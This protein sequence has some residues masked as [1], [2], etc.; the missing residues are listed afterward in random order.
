MM[1]TIL[2]KRRLLTTKIKMSEFSHSDGLSMTREDGNRYRAAMG[3]A[4]DALSA[5]V[6]EHE[7]L[8]VEGKT[9]VTA[10][11][12]ID[13]KLKE[14]PG[15]AALLESKK[16]A[17]SKVRD[18]AAAVEASAAK[19]TQRI[20]EVDPKT[21]PKV[22]LQQ[23]KIYHEKK[24]ND[25]L[26][27]LL[28]AAQSLDICFVIDATGSMNMG[29]VFNAVSNHIRSVLLELKKS[30]PRMVQR[31]SLVAYRDPG[32]GLKHFEVQEFTG[33]VSTFAN[34]AKSVQAGG[35]GDTCEDVVGALGKACE[36]D[37]QLHNR[38]IFLCGDSPAHGTKYHDLGA[39][40]GAD[41]HPMGLGKPSEPILHDLMQKR[42]NIVFWKVNGTT[43][44]MIKVFNE[45]CS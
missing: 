1:F 13:K 40:S 41:D 34:M 43:D 17:E 7:K 6:V 11:L 19:L 39:S 32:D 35:G 36:L 14:A 24:E 44:K 16:L 29:K 10:L 2:F 15:D 31:L 20:R 33:S 30:A 28:T 8:M 18:V 25:R 42:V 23:L 3:G 5:P 38:L 12:T 9:S 26:E 45:E 4:L 21:N 22:V 37:W 27:K